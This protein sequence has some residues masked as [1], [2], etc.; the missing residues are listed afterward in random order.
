MWTVLVFVCVLWQLAW[1]L[2]GLVLSAICAINQADPWDFYW[3]G[4]WSRGAVLNIEGRP[5][6]LPNNSRE[7]TI[8]LDGGGGAKQEHGSI[9]S[10]FAVSKS[11]CPLR[12][13]C[14]NLLC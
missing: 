7:L 5:S 6:R 2:S 13:W 1:T 11:K 12:T 10:L 8:V 9:I 14:G 3:A 4:N